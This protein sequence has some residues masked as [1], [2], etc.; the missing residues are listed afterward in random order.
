MWHLKTKF[1]LFAC[2]VL[3]SCLF[4]PRLSAQDYIQVT[5][6]QWTSIVQLSQ[7]LGSCIES[8]SEQIES[9]E[10]TIASSQASISSLK[11]SLTASANLLI[12]Q[13]SKLETSEMEITKQK[14]SYASLA[15]SYEKSKDLNK[16]LG[17]GFGIAGGIALAEAFFLYLKFR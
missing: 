12:E 5:R 9:L 3:L 8:Q 13:A 10:Q 11:Q 15:T 4:L 2:A 17:W 16:F 14:D 7:K 1:V 6:A